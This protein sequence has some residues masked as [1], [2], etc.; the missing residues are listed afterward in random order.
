MVMDRFPNHDKIRSYFREHVTKHGFGAEGMDWKD[1]ESQ[2]LRFEVIDRYID[3]SG[4]PTI[5]DVGCGAGDYLTFAHAKGC[6]PVYTGLDIVPEM[7]AHLLEVHPEAS[8]IVGGLES[9]SSQRY[10]YV[11]ASGTFNAKLDASEVDWQA[12]LYESIIEMCR[13]AQK[14]V[15]FNLM[16]PHVDYTYDRL[17]Y[18]RF[19]ELTAFIVEHFGRDFIIDHDY[20]L[21]EFTLMIRCT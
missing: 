2:F 9:I 15:V 4:S 18:P 7:I 20:A 1:Q 10:D 8:G 5:L 12:Y 3:Y 6:N 13:I 14:A 17:Y 21:Y 11:I 19:D 16:S